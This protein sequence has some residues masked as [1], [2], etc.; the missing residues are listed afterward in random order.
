VELNVKIVSDNLRGELSLVDKVWNDAM[1]TA[2]LHCEDVAHML[3]A[4]NGG[5]D[6]WVWPAGRRFRDAAEEFRKEKRK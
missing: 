6:S 1:E 2:A 4:A 5:E 3:F